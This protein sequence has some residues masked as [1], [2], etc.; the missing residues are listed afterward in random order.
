MGNLFYRYH[1]FFVHQIQEEYIFY[2]EKV[3]SYEVLNQLLFLQPAI[4][5]RTKLSVHNLPAGLYV[6]HVSTDVG[7]VKVK[8]VVKN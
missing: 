2:C 5:C 7:S 6:A 3:D 8:F 4:S 1:H